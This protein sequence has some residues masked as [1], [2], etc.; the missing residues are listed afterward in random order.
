MKL[1]IFFISQV[2]PAELEA[3]LIT[4]LK[5]D[6]VAVIGIP[7]EKAGELPK[8]FVVAK[9]DI[10]PEEVAA[11]VAETVEPHKK[12]RGGVEWSLLAR[13]VNPQAERF[14]ART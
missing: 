4:H 13:F 6:D 1:S 2:A 14:Y 3:L 9:G 12:L 11:L 8:A 7:D 10:T 5:I